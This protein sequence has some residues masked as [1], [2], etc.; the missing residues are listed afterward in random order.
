MSDKYGC[1]TVTEMA[2]VRITQPEDCE[3]MIGNALSLVVPYKR[4]APANITLP[5]P[6]APY[7]DRV[8]IVL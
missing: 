8:V 5:G 7:Q 4:I 6:G 3:N 2:T 1:W